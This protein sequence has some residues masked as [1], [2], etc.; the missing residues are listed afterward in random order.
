MSRVPYAINNTT[1]PEL[2]S[3]IAFILCRFTMNRLYQSNANTS[4]HYGERGFCSQEEESQEDRKR[5]EGKRFQQEEEEE[6]ATIWNMSCMTDESSTA[7][8]GGNTKTACSIPPVALPKSASGFV[9]LNDLSYL[10]RSSQSSTSNRM[11]AAHNASEHKHKARSQVAMD[12]HNS[13]TRSKHAKQREQLLHVEIC[14]N[15]CLT[16]E[17]LEFLTSPTIR[18]LCRWHRGQSSC[19]HDTFFKTVECIHL[20][21]GWMNC[22]SS[23]REC[24]HQ[25]RHAP[26]PSIT[27]RMISPQCRG[28]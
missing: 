9:H 14:A 13:R 17:Q 25:P 4:I 20:W 24:V 19:H 6:E 18:I 11:R 12:N 27:K 23:K 10:P 7:L 8:H 26:L 16:L 15:K 5:Q 1:M 3:S 22:Y 28:K 2:I 21:G